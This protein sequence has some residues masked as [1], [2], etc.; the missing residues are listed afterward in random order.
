M[1][2]RDSWDWPSIRI[3]RRMGVSLPI[4]TDAKMGRQ[5][6]RSIAAKAAACRLQR[7]SEHILMVVP[8]PYLNHNGGMIAFGPDRLLY[9]GR[10]DGGSRG[11]PQNRAKISGVAGEDS[12]HRCRPDRPYAIPPDN[13]YAA[14]GGRAEIFA[15]G[16]RNPWR[17]SFDRETGLLLAGRCWPIQMGRGRPCRRRRQLRLAYHG[18][19]TLLQPGG[20]L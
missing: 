8:Q 17:F 2:S 1:T 14:G 10:G 3:T 11:D 12:S 9:I 20:R 16:I 18:R 13:P 6:S 19:R 4:T 5:S 7:D 15:L